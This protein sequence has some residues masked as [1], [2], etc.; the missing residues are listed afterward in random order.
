[1]I[2]WDLAQLTRIIFIFLHGF[3][4]LSPTFARSRKTILRNKCTPILVER[5]A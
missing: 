5:Q 2:E 3:A 1:M 4:I